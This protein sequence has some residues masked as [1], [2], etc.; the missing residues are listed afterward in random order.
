MNSITRRDFLSSAAYLGLAAGF[1]PVHA[2]QDKKLTVVSW[3]GSYQKAQSEMV[4]QPVAQKLGIELFEQTYN[5][6]ADIRLRVRSGAVDWDIVSIGAGGAARASAE[7]L[8]TP[9]DYEVVDASSL[10]QDYAAEYWLGGDLY[11]TALAWRND[12]YSDEAPK[13]WADFWDVTRFPGPRAYRNQ[14]LG[15]LEPALLAEGVPA[16]QIYAELSTDNGLK[17]AIKK[18]ASLKPDIA[19]FWASGAHQAQYLKDG[20]VNMTSA[21]SGQIIPIIEDGLPIG[22]TYNDAILDADTYVV[23]SG[24]PNEK[25]AME[26]LNEIS[27]PEYQAA[28][29]NKMPY[30][31]VNTKAYSEGLISSERAAQLP[32]GPDN[33]S[34]HL[35]LDTEWWKENQT[36]AERL[37]QE[38]ITA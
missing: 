11:S 30:G 6:L 5:G 26:F 33:L 35:V 32:S 27:N 20:V 28:F 22:L 13:T 31:A 19:T 14:S 24:A 25:L 3:G 4:W 16:D 10:M 34:K 23:P 18:V 9:I 17:E 36:R 8:L 12:R 21:W 7:D 38:M 2:S 1:P 29:S 37:Y 15:H